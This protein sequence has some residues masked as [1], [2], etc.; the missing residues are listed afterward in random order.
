MLGQ[1]LIKIDT[2]VFEDNEDENSTGEENFYEAVEEGLRA[3][4]SSLDPITG[5]QF[6]DLTF[7]HNDGEGRIIKGTK[8]ATLP[9]TSQSSTG[10]M[11][12]VTQILDKLNNLPLDELVNS[13]IKVVEASAEPVDNIN[14]LIVDL[15]A[16]VKDIN[17][18]TSK[19]SFEVMP[20]EIEKVLKE[21]SDTLQSTDKMVKGYAD[22]SL[23]QNQLTQTLKVLTRTSEEMQMFLK[24]LNR[25][26]DSLIFGD[27]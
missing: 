20:D 6:I 21:L 24:M 27:N 5:M 22:D 1:V 12:S 11:T 15:Q 3:K 26:P 25:K 9:M 14:T 19:K 18:L 2:S 7:N 8:Y 4:I 17:Q 13:V 10:I 16:T 23:I